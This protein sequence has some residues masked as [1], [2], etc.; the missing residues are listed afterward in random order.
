MLKNLNQIVLGDCVELM[1]QLPAGLIPLTVTSPPF[2][3]LRR[4]D[5]W[6]DHFNFEAT[7]IELFR[8]TSPGGIVCWHVQEQIDAGCESGT[9][10]E[11]RL[12]FR[13]VGFCLYGTL[14]LDTGFYFGDRAYRYGEAPHY[15]FLLSKGRRRAFNPIVDI[16]NASA[17]Q[18]CKY[19]RRDKDGRSYGPYKHGIVPDYRQRT[20]IWHYDTGS[21]NSEGETEHPALM[22]MGLARDLIH[23][24][25]NPGDLVI[26]PFSGEGTTAV[27]AMRLRRHYLGFEISPYWVERARVRLLNTLSG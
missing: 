15:V 16:R 3:G 24:F 4:Y 12:Y 21:H 17:G 1:K 11:Q 25:S 6:V 19:R 22:H 20:H 2:D 18:P 26:D 7:A 10:S 23:S 9:A 14:I 8:I 13:S 27:A 5:G